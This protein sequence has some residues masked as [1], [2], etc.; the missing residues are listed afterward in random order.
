MTHNK[1][2]N[3]GAT[4]SYTTRVFDAEAS[5][6][7]VK[8]RIAALLQ[9][10][11]LEVLGGMIENELDAQTQEVAFNYSFNCFVED[12]AYAVYRAIQKVM[13]YS[14]HMPGPWMSPPQT[15]DVK[16]ADGSRIKVPWGTIA[17]PALGEDATVSM[18]YDHSDRKLYL[19]GE[20]ERRLQG[21]MDHIAE[22][23]QHFLDTE[24]IYRGRAI[25]LDGNMNPSFLNLEKYRDIP[26]YLSPTAE[27]N[28]MSI[29]A[30]ILH[31]DRCIQEGV[32]LKFG[33]IIVGEYGTGK[34]L[35]AFK[36]ALLANDNDWSFIYLKDP[37]KTKDMLKMAR[38]LSANGRGVLT[39]TEDIDMILTAERTLDMNALLNEIDGGD[40]KKL[41]I[42]SLFTTNHPEVIDPT[43]LRGKRTSKLIYLSALTAETASNF[44][45]NKL[46]DMIVGTWENAAALAEKLNVVP[47]FMEDILDTVITNR[48]TTG[49]S[50]VTEQDV[51]AAIHSYESQMAMSRVR[52]RTT[53]DFEQM[54]HLFSKIFIG[55]TVR[56][57]VDA[58]LEAADLK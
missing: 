8:D 49:E 40:T 23:T 45:G 4:K 55:V 43:M 56:E 2:K 13:G 14:M 22:A 12:G 37:T 19:H 26:I 58:A 34:T 31:T 44:I 21:W 7:E 25:M 20:C 54:M 1:G 47:A 36:T 53:S 3:T 52:A 29:R 41:P 42:I 35:L 32:D 50:T 18:K 51:I 11:P 16:F 10:H 9:D 39:F 6:R 17:L 30:R 38:Y 46:G 28:L 15:I 48:I 24:S 5:E 33:A 57:N 27:Y